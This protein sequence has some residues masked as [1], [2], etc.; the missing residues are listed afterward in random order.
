VLNPIPAQSPALPLIAVIAAAWALPSLAAEHSVAD[1][2]AFRAVM[3]RVQPGDTVILKNGEWRDFEILFEARGQP[4]RPITLTAETKGRVF[5]SGKSNLRL[6]GEHLVVSGLVFRD[7]YTP[8]EEVIAFRRDSKRLANYTRVTEVVIDAFNPLERS[9]QDQWVALHGQFN[10]VDHSQFVGKTNAGVT[11]AVIRQATEP[12]ENRHRIDHN[13]F[14]FRPPLGSNGGETIR[15]GTSDESLSDSHTVV[16]RNYFERCDGEVEIVSNKSGGNT[17][18]GN[19]FFESQGS[20]VLRHGNGNLV[21]DNVFI[22]NGR[23]HT[24]GIR[25][26]NARQTI[27][28]NYLEGLAGT[29]FA[30][31]LAVMNGVPNSAINRYHQVNAAAIEHNTI[32]DATRITLGAGADTERSA[33]PIGSR[34]A[35]NLIV[36]QR[37]EEVFLI[38]ADMAGLAMSGNVQNDVSKPAIARGVARQDV[39]LERANNGLLYPT[40]PAL[41]KAGAPRTLKPVTKQ[42]T[43]VDWYAKPAAERIDGE[44]D[45]GRVH[46]ISAR[47][48]ASLTDAIAKSG[49]GDT[50]EL[51]PGEYWVHAPI[52][53]VHPI[54][55]AAASSASKAS[56]PE[57]LVTIYFT[58]PSLFVLKRGGSLRLSGVKIS[59]AKAPLAQ[60]NVLIALDGQR[61]PTHYS[62]EVADSSF[63]ELHRS[64][65]FDFFAATPNSFAQRI[66]IRNSRFSDVSG[67]VIATRTHDQNDALYA[68]ERVQISAS[69]F[70]NVGQVADVFRGGRDESTFGPRFTLTESI[71]MGSGRASGASVRLVGALFT[72]ISN[73]RFNDSGP[74][75]VTHGVGAP[76]TVIADNGFLNTAL[77]V[78]HELYAKGVSRAVLTGN[79][80]GAPR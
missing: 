68:I 48:A 73:N 32:I 42:E 78:V 39:K 30:S 80:V 79:V 62:I 8:S 9:R 4:D 64:P 29:G 34:F 13:Y 63:V 45:R 49:S 31:A 51:E 33:P 16:E 3:T 40:D 20:L 46:R 22:G 77:P 36:S 21:E 19:T 50:V 65:A 56:T 60:G 71:V 6:A 67:H 61:A 69:E 47:S 27:R 59:G 23:A 10:R 58:Q 57:A 35:R 1:Q 44:F 41:V 54:T 2:A 7:G 25:V 53:V 17:F 43:G 52:A 37:G 66:E 75:E 76:H 74:V 55:I 18:R 70:N 72:N 26:I 11:L 24:G 5:I 38:E 14:G 12:L 15:I 28:G